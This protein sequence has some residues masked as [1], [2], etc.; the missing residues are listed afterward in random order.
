MS[1]NRKLAMF[2][3]ALIVF[4]MTLLMVAGNLLLDAQ[5][6]NEERKYLISTLEIVRNEMNERRNDMQKA[7]RFFAEDE[8]IQAA[9]HREESEILNKKTEFLIKNYKNVDYAVM[10]NSN[11]K[12]IASYSPEVQYHQSSNVAKLV[13]K[14]LTAGKAIHTMEIVPLDELYTIHSQEYDHFSIK[15]T[16]GIIG[17]EHYL[18]KA[19]LELVI[20]PVS[21]VENSG[22]V[23][24]AIVVADIANSDY[25]FPEYISSR[26]TEGFLVL[27]IDGIRV[28]TKATEGEKINELVGTKSN[29]GDRSNRAKGQ[30]F[31]KTKINDVNYIF[32]DEEIKNYAGEIV[33]YLSVGIDEQRFSAI[34]NDNRITAMAVIF[35]C[36][37]LML[38]LGRI[39]ANHI[40]APVVAVT[41]LT[42]KYSEKYLGDKL[43]VATA[44]TEDECII[45]LENFKDFIRNLKQVEEEKAGY[46]AKVQYE[47]TKQ[48]SLAKQLKA[49]NEN[50][51]IKVEE[52]TQ[53]LQT[54][55]AE[56]KK[57]DVAKSA[58]LANLSHE[59]RTP[60]SVI[61]NAADV[62]RDGYFGELN[63]KQRK[64]ILNIADCG[65]HL[66]H[67]IND[68]L[69]ISKLAAGKM[70]LNRQNF[71]MAFLLEDVVK[72]AE[73]LKKDKAITIKAE[74]LPPDFVVFAD[75]QRLKQIFYNIISN[76]IKFTDAGGTISIKAYQRVDK[77]E[78]LVKDTG[79]G[80]AAQDQQRI[81]CDFEQV[82]GTYNKH[83]QG[84]GLGLPIV[85]KLVELHGGEVFLKSKLGA[86]TEV[87]FTIPLAGQQEEE[88]G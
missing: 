28:A 52:R 19:L 16:E 37:F 65:N 87:I 10:V 18:R 71:N 70:T 2:I 44:D 88:H 15:L 51:E 40:S 7:C 55:V 75:Q 60:L 1:I 23:I 63:E 42:R 14:A 4:P 73:N 27:S 47:H 11:N 66:L 30:F 38:G 49:T 8:K 48:I 76:A 67:L 50:L 43:R 41:G 61:I 68:L 84:T 17:Q 6:K 56:L 59:L 69:D 58:L 24:G 45:L 12:L 85:K 80:I 79:I 53:H 3:V 21:D 35:F 57:L 9:I 82:E 29:E 36:L 83:Y 62:L 72:I 78:V 77:L 20:V 86:G 74:A 32:L 26:A 39:L 5:V 81:F 34:V 13:Q 54:V 22:Q 64:Y 46:L 25:Y 33:G 31:G